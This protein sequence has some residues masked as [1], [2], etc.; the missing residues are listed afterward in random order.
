MK[1]QGQQPLCMGSLR[2]QKQGSLLDVRNL[3]QTSISSKN[4]F[5]RSVWK[6][7]SLSFSMTPPPSLFAARHAE[8][9]KIGKAR[10]FKRFQLPYQG[11]GRWDFTKLHVGVR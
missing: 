11:I 2:L 10:L 8:K 9:N 7:E 3:R 1:H 4:V 5:Y 6:P